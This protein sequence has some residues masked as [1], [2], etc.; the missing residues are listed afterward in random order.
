MCDDASFDN[1]RNENLSGTDRVIIFSVLVI[2]EPSENSVFLRHVFMH[3][4]ISLNGYGR[5]VYENELNEYIVVVL[6]SG[7]ISL[8]YEL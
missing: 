6:M 4:Y 3:A 5:V 2:V 1:A 7:G 8:I